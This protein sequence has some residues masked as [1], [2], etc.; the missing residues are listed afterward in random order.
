MADQISLLS[1]AMS[2]RRG[3]YDSIP[4]PG[5]GILGF[6]NPRPELPHYEQ[7]PDIISPRT[8]MTWC[9]LIVLLQSR[10]FMGFKG[11]YLNLGKPV[12]AG[13]NFEVWRH[14][15]EKHQR[16][17]YQ[18]QDGEILPLG[19][20]V[21]LK[22]IIPRV[23]EGNKVDLADRKQLSALALDVCALT[24]PNL[25][26]HENIITLHGLLWD[27]HIDE[28]AAW[29]VLAFEY[30]DHSFAEILEHPTASFPL[31]MKID[32]GKAIGKGI[33][34]LH[35]EK[36]VHG[37]IKSEN[38]LV[39]FEAPNIFTP[40]LADFGSALFIHEDLTQDNGNETI[41]IGGTNPWRAPEV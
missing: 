1:P 34:A 15:V 40:K 35:T 5:R 20:L 30:C 22:R 38:I 2:V 23:D 10:G 3:A 4:N 16:M 12:G 28:R 11:D 33:F 14:R 31:D 37:D 8:G 18:N 41:W 36:I 39:K 17:V 9:D 21:A 24:N 6:P 13:S 27:S 29:P 19:T 25:R 26:Q 32:F 7:K